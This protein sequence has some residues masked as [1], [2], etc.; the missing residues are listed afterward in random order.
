MNVVQLNKKNLK[1]LTAT[2]GVS[3]A[4]YL[5]YEPIEELLIICY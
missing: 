5:M 1:S 3:S 4:D 2:C